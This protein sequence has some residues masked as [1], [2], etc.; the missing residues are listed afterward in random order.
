MPENHSSFIVLN[1]C[2]ISVSFFDLKFIMFRLFFVYS[3]SSVLHMHLARAFP[4]IFI[5]TCHKLFDVMK[6]FAQT[7]QM[8]LSM[9]TISFG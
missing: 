1:Q 8:C 5:E 2:R 9:Q 4:V 7:K 6:N 3:L